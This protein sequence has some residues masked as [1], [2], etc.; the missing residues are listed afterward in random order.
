MFAASNLAYNE[1]SKRELQAALKP[2]LLTSLKGEVA[3][4]SVIQ[5]SSGAILS[6][7]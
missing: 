2:S 7:G 3:F 6:A 5:C 1:Q 4:H